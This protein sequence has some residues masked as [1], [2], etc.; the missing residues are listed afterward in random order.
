MKRVLVV[1]LMLGVLAVPIFNVAAQAA[2]YKVGF[3]VMTLAFTWMTYSYQALI[4]EAAKYP[5]IELIV[6]NANGDVSR[7][8]EIIENFIAQG[9]DAII[10]DPIDVNTLIPVMEDAEARGIAFCTFDRRAFGGPFLFHVG[11]DDVFGGRLALEYCAA[12]LDGVGKIIHIE[13][14]LGASP[15]INRKK[16]IHEQLVYYPGLDLVY[17]QSGQFSREEGLRVM[18]DAIT[19]TGGDFDAVICANDDSALGAIQAMKDAGIDLNDVIVVGYDGVPDGLRAI[20]AGELNA[21]IQYPVSMA[22][23]VMQQV[24]EYLIDGTMPENPDFDMLPWMLI[25]DNLSE[26]ADFWPELG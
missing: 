19:S 11:C 6:D 20:L 17:E 10:T 24:A 8:V 23:L 14:Q 4:D 21:S 26:W 22:S 12:K 3:C 9:V 1:A 16:G 13:G 5:E 2:E 18:E 25:D 7:Q 15:A